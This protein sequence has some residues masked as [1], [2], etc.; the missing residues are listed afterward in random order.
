MVPEF[1]FSGS[2]TGGQSTGGGGGGGSLDVGI[3]VFTFGPGD[4]GVGSI[5]L[6]PGI[7]ID[8]IL[9]RGDW[10]F[11]YSVAG[12]GTAQPYHLRQSDL[13]KDLPRII[14]FMRQGTIEIVT[15][16]IL[17]FNQGEQG[18]IVYEIMTNTLTAET[19]WPVIGFAKSTGGGGGG[20]SSQ[21]L[22]ASDTVF[23][24]PSTTADFAIFT[25][26]LSDA[27]G[28][29]YRQ[30]NMGFLAASIT[31][32]SAITNDNPGI[33]TVVPHFITQSG[34]RAIQW[35]TAAAPVG[36]VANLSWSWNGIPFTVQLTV[37][38]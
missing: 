37:G 21:L 19:E 1:D 7:T 36:S 33:F 9:V 4:S 13:N 23:A 11:G 8:D 28:L 6:D 34:V 16:K 30:F 35:T 27:S 5:R 18:T 3:G 25:G 24:F 17:S 12:S 20:G 29:Q 10:Q 22:S 14:G 2:P 15:V 26:T 32:E 31:S 38:V